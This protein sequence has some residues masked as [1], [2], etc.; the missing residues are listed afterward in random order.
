MYKQT[1]NSWKIVKF[2]NKQKTAVE[3]KIRKPSV[4]S[5]GKIFDISLN[6]MN[7]QFV[8]KIE[9]FQLD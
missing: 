2:S 7:E 5:S 9:M 1:K 8:L 4:Q 3:T 6:F